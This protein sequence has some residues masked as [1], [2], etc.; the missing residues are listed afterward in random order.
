MNANIKLE[1]KT[2]TPVRLTALM[3][4]VAA[5][6]QGNTHY[7]APP[8]APATLQAMADA[9]EAAITLATE[10][11]RQSKLQ[12]NDRMAE[13]KTV[14]RML[15]DYA[16]QMAQGNVTI[17]E[18]SGF[19]LARRSGP[20]QPMGTPFMKGARMTG[21][22]G[23]VELRWS[24][25]ANRRTYQVYMT[26]TDPTEGEQ[27]TLIGITGKITHQ[28][29]GLE[30]YKAYWFCVSAVGALGEG[31]KSDPVLGRAA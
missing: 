24:G 21:R 11:S 9:L 15:A 23:E 30:P 14:M 13:A 31:A 12:R 10:G 17:L 20:P 18:S 25:V 27:W 5:K 4:N 26:D 19:E 3:R 29:T 16:R 22:H 2:L 1:L 7:P 28:V 8:V 6:M